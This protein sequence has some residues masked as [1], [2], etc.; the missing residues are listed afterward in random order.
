MTNKI[1]DPLPTIGTVLNEIQPRDAVHMAVMSV[2]AQ[3]RLCPGDP[4]SEHGKR[5]KDSDSIGI[6]DPFLDGP[7]F[8]GEIFWI[9]IYPRTI[10]GLRHHWEHPLLEENSTESSSENK[11]WIQNWAYNNQIG[12]EELMEAAEDFLHSGEYWCQ[13][14]RF[15]GIYLPEQFWDHYEKVTGTKVP[16]KDKHSF[17]SC[18]C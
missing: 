4:V 9:F 3:E 8:K 18:S 16:K 11:K 15:E 14:E 17:F 13:G 6:V 1:N 12:Y 2:Q 7:I 5:S 10:S